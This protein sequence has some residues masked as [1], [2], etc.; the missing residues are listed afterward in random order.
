MRQPVTLVLQAYAR[1]IRQL[2]RADPNASETALAPAFQQLLEGLIPLL[3]VAPRLTVACRR[4]AARYRADR[5]RRAAARVR[6]AEAAGK[7]GR[8]D[9]LARPSRP[10]AIRAFSR[11]VLLGNM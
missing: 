5:A 4:R 11:A 6:G 7:A 9:A 8:P 10:A 3:P 2:L 1:R